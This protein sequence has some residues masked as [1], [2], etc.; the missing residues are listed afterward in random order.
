MTLAHVLLLVAAAASTAPSPISREGRVSAPEGFRARLPAGFQ[1][2]V[3]AAGDGRPIYTATARDGRSAVTVSTSVAQS[4]LECGSE[5]TAELGLEEFTSRNGLRGCKIVRASEDGTAALALALVGSGRAVVVVTAAAPTASAAERLAEDVTHS[6]EIRPELVR[7]AAEAGDLMRAPDRRLIGC[8]DQVVGVG[9]L[10][11]GARSFK[12]RCFREDFTFVQT[13]QVF[14]ASTT[15][16][17]PHGDRPF[18]TAN[19]VARAT[20]LS[21]PI[22][23]E[24]TWWAEED[25]LMLMF[26]DGDVEGELVIGDGGMIFRGNFW[27]R[28][29]DE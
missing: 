14:A 23:V 21:A 2:L 27:E 1:Y 13:T 7:A 17:E 15:Y 3:H 18:T 25:A 5:E 11:N 8:F 9:T 4:S 29:A 26:E 12:K 22:A 6:V 10:N 24:G 19:T 16:D 28:A 20:G